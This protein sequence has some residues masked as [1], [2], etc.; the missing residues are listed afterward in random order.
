MR[1]SGAHRAHLKQDDG[2]APLRKLKGR[3]SARQPSA[4]YM[5][6]YSQHSV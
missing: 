6:L 1:W 3:F 5:N 4:N 2:Y